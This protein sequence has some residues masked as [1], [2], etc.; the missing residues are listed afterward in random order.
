MFVE[1]MSNIKFEILHNLF[2]TTSN[3]HAFEKFLA[4]CHRPCCTK[5]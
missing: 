5:R 2:R 1:L 3:L 4:S